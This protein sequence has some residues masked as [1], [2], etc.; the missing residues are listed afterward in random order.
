[1]SCSIDGPRNFLSSSSL[2]KPQFNAGDIYYNPNGGIYMPPDCLAAKQ[3]LA[4]EIAEL[5]KEVLDLAAQLLAGTVTDEDLLRR[6]KFKSDRF[7][8]ERLVA[9]RATET[10]GS[11]MGAKTGWLMDGVRLYGT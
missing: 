6:C 1:M 3:L 9:Q 10:K 4:S 11:T 7:L 8:L 2:Y 5:K